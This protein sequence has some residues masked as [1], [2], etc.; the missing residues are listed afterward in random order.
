MTKNP[1]KIATAGI[2]LFL[3]A[4]LGFRVVGDDPTPQFRFRLISSPAFHTGPI[5]SFSAAGTSWAVMALAGDR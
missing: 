2:V 5:S 3:A 4:A 1:L